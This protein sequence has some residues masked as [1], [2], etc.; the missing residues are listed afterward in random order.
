MT[1]AATRAHF[2]VVAARD[3]IAGDI[4]RAGGVRVL[5]TD[6][7]VSGEVHLSLANGRTARVPGCATMGIYR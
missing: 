4:L 2:Q 1:A 5:D 6:V 7:T 3:I